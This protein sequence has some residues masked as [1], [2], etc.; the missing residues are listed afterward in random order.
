MTNS[1]APL[2]VSL[3]VLSTVTGGLAA[4]STKCP[5]PGDYLDP[6]CVHNYGKG[7]GAWHRWVLRQR[8]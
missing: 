3:D 8:V 2:E 1:K 6:R 7:P 4:A 5:R